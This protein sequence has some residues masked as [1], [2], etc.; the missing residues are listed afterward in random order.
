[1]IRLV[2]SRPSRKAGSATEKMIDLRWRG[3]TVVISRLTFPSITRSAAYVIALMCQFARNT[4]PGETVSNTFITKAR[5]SW[6]RTES[7][8]LRRAAG[9]SLVR[10]CLVDSCLGFVVA[11]FLNL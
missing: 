11:D 2:G 10:R 9:L 7:R 6:D 5:K 8:Y 3:G 1:M 4:S